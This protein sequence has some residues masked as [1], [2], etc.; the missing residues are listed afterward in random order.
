MT[1]NLK[2]ITAVITARTSYSKMRTILTELNNKNNLK[3]E[4]I[5]SASAV[6]ENYGN[7]E[8]QIRKDKLKISYKI[9]TLLDDKSLHSSTKSVAL[10]IIQFADL[11][12]TIKPNI[13]MVMADRYE[14][15]APV[16]AASY[17]N[18]PVAHVQGGEISGNIDEK[19]R[20]AITKFSDVHFPSTKKSYLN[21]VKMGENKKNIFLTGCPSM[22]LAKKIKNKKIVNLDFYK[23]YKGVGA[24]FKYKPR[25]YII[26]MFHP[27]T[28]EIEKTSQ[29]TLKLLQLIKKLD[30]Y[31]YWFWPNADAG[32]TIIT[33]IIRINREFNKFK[34]IHLFKNMDPEDFLILLNNSIGI[35]GNSSAGIRESSYLGI[36]SVNIGFRQHGREKSKNVL[37]IKNLSEKNYKKIKF[38]L[39][40]KFSSS[41]LYGE[42]NAG[43]K[44]SSILSNKNFSFKK[45]LNN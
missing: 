17:Q 5:C 9:H 22:D 33:K 7:I 28:N 3:L 42:G 25:N 16:I 15:I 14:V 41:N 36:P 2:K 10:S 19:V 18:I 21:L 11:F 6:S 1:K 43:K 45:M 37:D 23:K 32:S 13:V 35:I 30:F 26:V 44:I 34:K 4:I 24:Y 39:K 29:Y 20:H 40:L 8:K 38:H 27:D 12:K 31:T